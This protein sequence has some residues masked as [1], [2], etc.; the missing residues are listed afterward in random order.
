MSDNTRKNYISDVEKNFGDITGSY[1]ELVDLGDEYLYRGLQIAS[2]LDEDVTLKFT[3][4]ATVEL[5]VPAG[6]QIPL[7]NF[8]HDG[9]IEIKHNGS[10]PTTGFL[11]LVSWRAE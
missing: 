11:K 5:N 2:T 6:W 10:A 7:P 3:N 4:T 8:W 1:T 9:I